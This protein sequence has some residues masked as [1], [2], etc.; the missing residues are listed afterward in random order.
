MQWHM[1]ARLL[2]AFR[3]EHAVDE[4][5]GEEIEI[6]PEAFEDKLITGPMPFQVKFTPRSQKHVELIERELEEVSE[7]L[8]KWE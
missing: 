8:K 3:I 4:K 7:L 2:W 5:T 1:L 6:D